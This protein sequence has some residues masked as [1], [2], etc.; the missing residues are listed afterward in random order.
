MTIKYEANKDT[1]IRGFVLSAIVIYIIA[2]YPKYDPFPN[3][4]GTLM[5]W[6]LSFYLD[7]IPMAFRNYILVRQDDVRYGLLI[8]PECSGLL[9]MLVFIIVV[10]MTPGLKLRH[11][12][13][14]IFFIP[15]LFI[16]NS[17][18][19]ATG[20]IFADL[21]NMNNLTVYHASIGQILMFVVMIGT[22]IVFLK[23]FGYFH[24]IDSI[25]PNQED[26]YLPKKQNI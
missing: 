4:T 18:R 9:V 17:I 23:T 1:I 20:V 26:R 25:T 12:F 5:S 2:A 11:R 24:K 7:D 22:Y 21:T 13:Y 19:V 8:S 10:F 6:I 15:I 16:A 3:L 14:S